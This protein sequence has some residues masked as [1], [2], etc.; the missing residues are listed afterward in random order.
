MMQ[1]TPELVVL[2][3]V[4]GGLIWLG[5]IGL[6]VILMA[7]AHFFEHTSQQQTWF[8]LYVLPIVLTTI[9]A[10]RYLVRTLNDSSNLTGD[11]LANVLLL[12]AGLLL[13]GLGNLLYGKMMGNITDE[14]F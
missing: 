1:N 4:L 3:V 7:I 8:Q 14:R 11:P 9:A 2:R 13:I 5:V 12:G 10:I 6:Q